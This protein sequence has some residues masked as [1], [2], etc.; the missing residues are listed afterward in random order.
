MT[1]QRLASLNPIVLIVIAVVIIGVLII[2]LIIVVVVIVLIA[3][4]ISVL[5]VV[6]AFHPLIAVLSVVARSSF[7]RLVAVPVCIHDSILVVCTV[8][9]VLGSA[10]SVVAVMVAVLTH[11]VRVSRL[12]IAAVLASL[13]H[14]MGAVIAAT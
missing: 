7:L 11:G 8:L 10:F 2:V 6:V 13:G 9:H 4:I 14:R 12:I 3:G 5:I 1:N